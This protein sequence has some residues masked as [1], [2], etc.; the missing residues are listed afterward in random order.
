MH[1]VL[2]VTLDDLEGSD[3]SMH[4]SL[5]M[6]LAHPLSDL[7]FDEQDCLYFSTELQTLGETIVVDLVEGGRALPVTDANKA[8]YVQLVAQHR[9][10]S[11]FAPQ[12]P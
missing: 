12:V 7:G 3:P 9:T 2:Q 1:Y 6:L 5:N 11:A 8:D 4:K 10:T